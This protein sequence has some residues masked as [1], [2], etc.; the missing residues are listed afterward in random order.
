[1]ST[2]GRTVHPI[3]PIEDRRGSAARPHDA[4]TTEAPACPDFR[5]AAGFL[6]LQSLPR[7]GPATAL[8]AT[9]HVAAMRR[10]VE[11]HGP[12]L[13]EAFERAQARVEECADADVELLSFFDERYPNRLRELSDPPPLLYVR[14][15]ANL[16]ARRRLVAV[17]GTREP[18]AP[19]IAAA[20]ALTAVLAEDGW[21]IV[22]GLAKG[23]D[24][25]AHCAAV[26]HGAPTIAVL[27]G[28]LDRIYPAENKGLA[29]RILDS[30]GALISEQ[31]CGEPPRP[32]HLVARDRLQ[33][34]LSV[35]VVV[36]QTGLSSGTMHTARFAASQGRALFCAVPPDAG[37]A[38]EGLRV[39]LERPARELCS[40]VAA[41][42][43]ARA[44]C[45]R[46]GERPL[47]HPVNREN[48]ADFV[49]AV[50]LARRWRTL[51]R[52]R[53]SVPVTS[54]ATL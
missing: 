48:L 18:T 12:R 36:A 15:D 8:R 49:G 29:A 21:S 25:V 40:T 4:P 6:A 2:V 44:L 46:L 42:R 3:E 54:R 9:L 13:D 37:C 43:G 30:G 41:W 47:A 51:S 34:G 27:G 53:Q 23:I 26:E 7:V 32:R 1:M 19:G 11:R 24:T 52:D 33:S 5:S 35:A 17:I 16:L 14:G 38:S 31:P 10:L 20:E 28:G 50:E 22:S 45:A 39:L